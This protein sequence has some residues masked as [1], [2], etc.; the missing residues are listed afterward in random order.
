MQ[1]ATLPADEMVKE[2][3]VIL[4]EM[5][6]N[7]DDPGQRSARR[8]FE[9]AYT[10]SPYR[11]T[12]IGYPDIYN[13]VSR[14][15]VFAYYKEKYVAN[16]VFFVVA[17]DMNAQ[18]AEDQIRAAYANAKLQA[19][20]PFVLP[21][22]PRQIAPR[23]VIE[24]ASIELAHFHY[25]WH[26]P[27]LRHADI[28]LLDVLATVLGNGRSSRLFQEIRDRRGLVSS[29]DTWTYTQIGRASCRERV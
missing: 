12:I 3:Q 27:D 11:F 25:S 24:E 15:D 22:E 23:E 9:T 10:R 29:I 19:L 18:E 14:E 26:I 17:G 1:N 13:R 20:P 6:M 8:L 16:N 5:D 21:E 7:Q 28:P 2:K 4:R